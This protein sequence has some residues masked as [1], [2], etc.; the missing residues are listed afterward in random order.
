[1]SRQSKA[2][3]KRAIAKQFSE[4]RKRG[5]KGPSRTTTLHKKRYGYRTNPL[6]KERIA[7]AFKAANPLPTKTSGKQILEGAGT[8]AA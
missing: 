7:E 2:V 5:E 8:A 6:N 3:S 1:M 4:A